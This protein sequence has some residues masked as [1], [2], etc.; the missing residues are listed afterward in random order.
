[1]VIRTKNQSDR[2]EEDRGKE[3]GGTACDFLTV[4]EQQTTRTT[5]GRFFISDFVCRCRSAAWLSFACVSVYSVYGS[6]LPLGCHPSIVVG[7]GC[8]KKARA[9][10]SASSTS[11]PQS[12]ASVR[13][14]GCRT[15]VDAVNSALMW[16]GSSVTQMEHRSSMA[17]VERA[18]S[19]GGKCQRGDTRQSQSLHVF[20]RKRALYVAQMDGPTKMFARWERL[21]AAATQPSNSLEE[22]LATL[23]TALLYYL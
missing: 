20:V 8:G 19:V 23:V 11:A 17:I 14:V 4:R 13:Q 5:S 15:T 22:D 12:L 16:R 2:S 9:A 18:C 21:A 1:M 3:T 10:G 6:T 7:C